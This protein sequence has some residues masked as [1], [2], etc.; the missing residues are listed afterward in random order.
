MRSSERLSLRRLWTPKYW[1]AWFVLGLLRLVC[2]LPQ[3]WRLGIGFF[4][5]RLGHRLAARRRAIAQRNIEVCFPEL[6]PEQRNDMTLRHF[7]AL[8]ASFIEMGIARWGSEKE[9]LALTRVEGAEHIENATKDG[10]GIILLSAHFSSLEISG[11]ALSK[12]CPP[13][14]VV[15]RQ[16][17]NDLFTDVLRTTRQ[18]SARNAIEKNDIKNMIRS[19]RNGVPVWYAPDQSYDRKQS[20][21]LP[22]FGIPS[23]TN[24]ATGTLAKLGKA[25]A[26][27][28]FP[29]RLEDGSYILTILPPL[30]D[31]PSGNDEQDTMKYVAILEEQIRRCPE[32]YIW[33]Y[34]KFK[35]R[36]E[37]LPDAYANLDELK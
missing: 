10:Q 19:L 21:L 7:E 12:V 11:C 27:P 29:R 22:F 3:R 9:L 14:D 23:M 36:P 34:R 25:A 17:R 33:T 8:G 26:V 32:Q 28:F 6:T 4:I 31:F 16:F 15:Y 37:P 13:F 5:G 20:A 1:P 30:D 2:L 24:T 18:R 35:G